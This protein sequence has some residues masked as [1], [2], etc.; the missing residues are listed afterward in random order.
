MFPLVIPLRMELKFCFLDK[1]ISPGTS[2]NAEEK[3]TLTIWTFSVLSTSA[4][5]TG[6]TLIY[7]FQSTL[8]DKFFRDICRCTLEISWAGS[9][10]LQ[11][12]TLHNLSFSSHFLVFIMIRLKSSR[13][14]WFQASCTF[15]HFIVWLTISQIWLNFGGH[16]LWVQSLALP[17]FSWFGFKSGTG[18]TSVSICLE[19]GH[20]AWH[21][22]LLHIIWK[23][24]SYP[25]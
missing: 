15:I 6:Y 25:F 22:L 23:I 21:C 8:F 7:G 10:K 12:I 17:I 4:F 3:V 24:D 18:V 13:H 11:N 5:P 14:F 1:Q 20:I 16:L 2:L 19:R 9:Y